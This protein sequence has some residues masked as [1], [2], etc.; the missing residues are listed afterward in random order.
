[1]KNLTFLNIKNA[2]FILIL[3]LLSF[4]PE[5]MV[6]S[7]APE[8]TNAGIIGGTAGYPL[9]SMYNSYTEEQKMEYQLKIQAEQESYNEKI[10]ERNL[11]KEAEKK[12]STIKYY[13]I[14]QCILILLIAICFINTGNE[15][16]EIKSKVYTE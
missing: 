7:K 15:I 9:P 1:M 8:N 14:F 3:L 16:N 5:Y 12:L 4:I 11:K 2:G 6:F 10:K 13:S